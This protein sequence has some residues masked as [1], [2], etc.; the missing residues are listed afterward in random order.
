MYY[1]V[2]DVWPLVCNGILNN[3]II[4]WVLRNLGRV[5]SSGVRSDGISDPKLC[6]AR[7]FFQKLYIDEFT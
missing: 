1:F 6:V 2:L 3:E 4:L 7:C 5:C